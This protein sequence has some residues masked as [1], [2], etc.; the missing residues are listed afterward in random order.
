MVAVAAYLE[1]FSG[2][3]LKATRT[4]NDAGGWAEWVVFEK[5]NPVTQGTGMCTEVGTM[6]AQ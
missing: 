1:C 6:S 4:G 2:A 3:G 5:Q